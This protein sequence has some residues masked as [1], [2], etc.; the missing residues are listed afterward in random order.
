MV[1]L[2]TA[3]A[4]DQSLLHLT[5]VTAVQMN[6]CS[7]CVYIWQYFQPN[8]NTLFRPNRIQIEY[9]VQP[10]SVTVFLLYFIYC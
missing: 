1:A 5:N 7:Y 9:S 8:T 3:A 10:V 6:D 2:K 4:T